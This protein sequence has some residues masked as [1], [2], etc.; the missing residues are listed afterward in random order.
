ML[1]T[2]YTL[3][4]DLL[5]EVKHIQVERGLTDKQMAEILGYKNRCS[6]AKIKIGVV[7]AN[8][9][10]QMRVLRA[11]PGFHTAPAENAQGSAKRGV[12]ALLDKIVL[13]VKKF[14]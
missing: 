14:V 5:E 12:K 1:Y 7:P 13:K 11:F 4:M 8:E 6:W 2:C 10:F 9:V 3:S